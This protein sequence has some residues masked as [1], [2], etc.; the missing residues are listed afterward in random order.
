MENENSIE[1]RLRRAQDLQQQGDLEAAKGSYEALL[2][3][4]PDEPVALHYL[5]LVMHQLKDFETANQH[6]QRSVELSP[7]NSVFWRNYAVC[8]QQQGNL[9]QAHEAVQAAIKL[10][11]KA[12]DLYQLAANIAKQRGKLLSVYLNLGMVHYLKDDLPNALACYQ[13]AVEGFPRSVNAR[14]SLATCYYQLMDFENAEICFRKTIELDPQHG[15]AHWNLALLLLL[16]GNYEEGWEEYQWRW[17]SQALGHTRRDFDQPSWEGEAL[18]GRTLMVYVEQGLGDAIQ[19]AR[20]IP[21]IEK[22]GGRV[23]VECQE[24]Q[25]RLF[26]RIDG[27]DAVYPVMHCGEDFDLQLPLMDLARIFRV[28]VD[29]IP[30]ELP[31]LTA[32]DSCDIKL[33]GEGKK[34]GLVWGGRPQHEKDEQRSIPLKALAPLFDVEG[35][36]WFSLQ[37]GDQ[38]VELEGVDFPIVNLDVQ[39]KDF[40]DTAAIMNQLDLVITVDSAPAHLAGALGRPVWIMDR[41]FPDW[42]WLLGRE[43]SPWYPTLRIFRQKELYDWSGVIH[44]VATAL[45]AL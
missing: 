38:V 27:V 7:Q 6:L 21:M 5:G 17:Q 25:M 35:I 1:A 14:Y 44:A 43:D 26:S 31:Y 10:T 42:R 24:A 11:P 28:T 33:E 15:S 3:E 2:E 34:V 20:F 13:A 37:K 40:D 23:I 9:D 30:Q 36:S 19:F 8:M 12:V 39:I 18:A 29:S 16:E 45:K 22:D 4:S 32:P 41:K